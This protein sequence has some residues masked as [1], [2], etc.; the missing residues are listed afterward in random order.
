[1]DVFRINK[2]TTK[3]NNQCSSSFYN[4]YNIYITNNLAERGKAHD[5]VLHDGGASLNATYGSVMTC[6]MPRI[7]TS[8]YVGG[9]NPK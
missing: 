4:V 8:T 9:K 1:M 3:T 5:M 6:D 7:Y 2:T